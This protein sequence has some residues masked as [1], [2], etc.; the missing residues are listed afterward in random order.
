MIAG[1]D[2]V[3]FAERRLAESR[4][5]MKDYR[6]LESSFVPGSVERERASILIEE[7][8]VLHK[9]MDRLCHSAHSGRRQ[10]AN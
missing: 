8:E 3:A 7:I 4:D 6:D 9:V 5:R 10:P 1:E 2:F